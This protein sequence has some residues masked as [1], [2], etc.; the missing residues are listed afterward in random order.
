MQKEVQLGYQVHFVGDLDCVR[1]VFYA[2]W[3]IACRWNDKKLVGVAED[4]AAAMAV[5][6]D[7]TEGD[8]FVSWGT[9]EMTCFDPIIEVMNAHKMMVEHFLMRVSDRGTGEVHW[10]KSYAGWLT[11]RGVATRQPRPIPSP[12]HTLLTLLTLLTRTLVHGYYDDYNF[13]A[14]AIPQVDIAE[15]MM[16]FPADYYDLRIVLRSHKLAKAKCNVVPWRGY[17]HMD[18][19]ERNTN[20]SIVGHRVDCV[21]SDPLAS[22]TN[23]LYAEMHVI[24]MVSRYKEWC[25]SFVHSLWL[26]LLLRADAIGCP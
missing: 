12:T 21:E 8:H 22:S 3:D 16:R 4:V 17:H 20:W 10:Q 19:Q 26:G 9:A 6:L 25:V 13:A 14:A 5:E 15:G 1:A 7:G 11:V 18:F 2:K 23:K 24:V